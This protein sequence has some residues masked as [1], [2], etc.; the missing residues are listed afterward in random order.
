MQITSTSIANTAYGQ[1]FQSRNHSVP[2][3]QRGTSAPGKTSNDLD[4]QQQ[5]EIQALKARDS[6]VRAHEQAHLA[7]AGGLATS[8]ASFQYV[9]GPDG[10][11]YASGGEVGI[12]VSP[13]AND[14]QATLLKA[15][16]IRRAALA[17]AQ[18]S[19]QDVSVASKAAAM[20][21]KASAELLLKSAQD[22]NSNGSLLDVVA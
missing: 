15:E 3:Q 5:R 18:P 4:E 16:T 7:A 8:G 11:R 22:S 19:G 13:V 9:T 2:D 1:R 12:D 21:N 20:A 10:Q 6:E 17:P 14:P